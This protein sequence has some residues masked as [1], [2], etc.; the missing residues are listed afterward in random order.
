ME[1]L[2]QHP[3]PIT[4]KDNGFTVSAPGKIILVGEY[5]VLY[6]AAAVAS[7]IPLRTHLHVKLRGQSEIAL[8]LP[9]IDCTRTWNID[10]LPWDAFKHAATQDNYNQ[11]RLLNPNLIQA[12]EPHVKDMSSGCADDKR[13]SFRKT[14]TAF[15]YLLLSLGS[16]G[17]N[18]ATYT[19]TS[20]TP[21]G[22]G[23]GSSASLCVCLAAG[24]LYHSSLAGKSGASVAL[25]SV[26]QWAGTAEQVFHRNASGIDTA[27]ST[28]GGTLMLKKLGLTSQASIIG[29]LPD[30]RMKLYVIDT[31]TERSTAVMFSN[32]LELRTKYPLMMQL[33]I[34]GIGAQS[35]TVW[36]LLSSGNSTS[37]LPGYISELGPVIQVIH[38]Y[39]RLLKASSPRIERVREVLEAGGSGWVKITG[40][41][42]GGCVIALMST[43]IPDLE[44]RSK[45]AFLESEGYQIHEVT[46]GA[47]GVYIEL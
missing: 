40:A 8:H 28:Y 7:A 19:V 2:S 13:Y 5:A 11:L 21:I 41:G 46:S 38:K 12:L 6:G 17:L 31:Q 16:R 26:S 14:C 43:S 18:E 45:I 32:F 39:L 37:Q 9:D 1:G 36:D 42:Q 15:L 3:A 25:D 30:A 34:D 24:M 47:S 20:D 27:V 35:Q 23:L 44:L 22:G 4:P 29:R 33:V 10:V